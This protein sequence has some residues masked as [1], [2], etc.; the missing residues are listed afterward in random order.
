VVWRFI[1]NRRNPS[2]TKELV[3]LELQYCTGEPKPAAARLVADM[4]REVAG[5]R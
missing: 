5:E 1:K 3:Q 4:R 2:L